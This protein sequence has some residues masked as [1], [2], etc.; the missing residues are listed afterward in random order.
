MDAELIGRASVL[1]GS[2]RQKA[3][4]AIDF[5]V[6]ISGIKKIG[7]HV[8]CRES[9]LTVHVGTEQSLK[10]VPPVIEKTVSIS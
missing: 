7:E 5:T 2:E 1:P 8:E 10:T 4:D 6:G 9:L 3:G